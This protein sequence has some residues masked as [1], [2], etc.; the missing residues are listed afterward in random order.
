[1]RITRGPSTTAFHK[2]KKTLKEK[3]IQSTLP[4]P[5]VTVI[6]PKSIL[7]HGH[8]SKSN[9]ESTKGEEV[10]KKRVEF[11]KNLEEERKADIDEKKPIDL[12]PIEKKPIDLKPIEKKPVDL[13]PTLTIKVDEPSISVFDCDPSPEPKSSVGDVGVLMMSKRKAKNW[14]S[15]PVKP[16]QSPTL[17][18]EEKEEE[19]EMVE[20]VS[21]SPYTIKGAKVNL[22]GNILLLISYQFIYS[23]RYDRY[24]N[25]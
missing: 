22:L 7:S 11:K 24:Q 4:P 6:E 12:K 9:L 17:I 25:C 14:L 8:D 1:M 5:A 10:Q 21:D 2:R 20:E 15:V 3:V 23:S 19:E 16:K 18:P 13:K